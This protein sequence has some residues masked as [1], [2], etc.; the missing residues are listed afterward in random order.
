MVD[1]RITWTL[2]I[3]EV[4]K[5]RLPGDESVYVFLAFTIVSS[6]LSISH[7]VSQGG[8]HFHTEKS[9]I[10]VPSYRRTK[11]PWGQYNVSLSEK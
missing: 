10:G 2:C 1:F 3:G 11:R 7:E 6:F 9:G 8:A 4:R 5:P